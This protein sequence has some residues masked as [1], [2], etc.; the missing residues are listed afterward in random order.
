[1]ESMSSQSRQ[2]F[3]KEAIVDFVVKKRGVFM[4]EYTGQAL[5][6]LA[7]PSKT[8]KLK[9]DFLKA[10][11]V[12]LS[13][14]WE[15]TGPFAILRI[16]P[17]TGFRIGNLNE[18]N[19][20]VKVFADTLGS[21]LEHPAHFYKHLENCLVNWLEPGLEEGAKDFVKAFQA[22]Q[23]DFNR[24]N[25]EARNRAQMVWEIFGIHDFR[26][27]SPSPCFADALIADKTG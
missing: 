9:H 26:S 20:I 10:F 8:P 2:I 12:C 14:P 11:T 5:S 6:C 22:T 3:L 7:F 16:L 18:A 23:N 1:M 27:A 21:R 19:D 15:K 4:G 13:D 17:N 24:G 25:P